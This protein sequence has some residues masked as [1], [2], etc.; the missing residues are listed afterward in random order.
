MCIIIS[1]FKHL[2]KSTQCGP[3]ACYNMRFNVQ[4]RLFWTVKLAKFS[5]F[6]FYLGSKPNIYLFVKGI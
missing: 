6:P 2:N 5:R 4:L 1:N 3:S